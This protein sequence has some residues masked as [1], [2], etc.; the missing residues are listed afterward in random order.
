MKT[1]D[2]SSMIVLYNLVIGV[3]VMLSSEKVASLAGH[4]NKA[5]HEKVVRLTHTSI[6]TFGTCV[7]VLSAGIYLAFHVLKIGV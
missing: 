4:L 5:H 6:F 2:F 1:V 3:L 7:T